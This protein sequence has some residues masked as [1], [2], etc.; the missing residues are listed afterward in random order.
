MR[1]F[2]LKQWFGRVVGVAQQPVVVRRVGLS[3]LDLY[4]GLAV[5]EG[6]P[7]FRSVVEVVRRLEERQVEE[8]GAPD[9]PREVKA[10]AM[11]AQG[12]LREVRLQLEAHR[13]SAPKVLEQMAGAGQ[14]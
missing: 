14:A 5:D 4:R 12:L 1:H 3:D 7:V 13:L 9:V 2:S 6:H 11:A 8:F 10:D